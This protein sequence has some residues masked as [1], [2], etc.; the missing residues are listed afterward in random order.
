MIYVSHMKKMAAV[1]WGLFVPLACNGP[2][3]SP[4]PATEAAPTQDADADADTGSGTDTGSTKPPITAPPG[5]AMHHAQQCAQELG[6]LPQFNCNDAIEIPV[7]VDGAVVSEHVEACDRPAALGFPCN[8]GNRVGRTMGTHD[9]GAPRPEVVFISLCREE[10]GIGVIGHNSE[11]GATCFFTSLQDAWRPLPTPSD[12]EAYDGYWDAPGS[13]AAAG[14]QTCHQA[15]PFLHSPWID[16]I[17]DPS[18][19][20]QPIVPL[21]GSLDA[22]YFIVG[23][24]FSQPLKKVLSDNACTSC[25]RAQCSPMALNFELGRL[26]MPA[27]F[28]AL[29]L[30]DEMHDDRQ[31]L[32]SWCR[33]VGLH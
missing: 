32:N 16:Q 31:E 8:V 5:T 13:V 15:D 20:E 14:C 25:H 2:S 26:E 6:P 9:G 24:E 29:L 22:P 17:S 33:S 10:G 18:S 30:L 1:F 12:P 19:P 11:T 7:T 28:A 23:D 21:L 27:P 3:P 4:S